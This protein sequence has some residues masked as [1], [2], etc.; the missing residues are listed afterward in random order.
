ME[1]G[2]AFQCTPERSDPVLAPSSP[3]CANLGWLAFVLPQAPMWGDFV[4]GVLVVVVCCWWWYDVYACRLL[5]VGT[6]V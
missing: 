2:A 1:L 3:V 5:V 4:V 6:W